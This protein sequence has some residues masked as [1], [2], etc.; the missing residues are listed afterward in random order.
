MGLEVFLVFVFAL[1]IFRRV[2]SEFKEQERKNNLYQDGTGDNRVMEDIPR[3]AGDIRLHTILTTTNHSERVGI[4]RRHG[5]NSRDS[6]RNDKHSL[7]GSHEA[8]RQH[9]KKAARV[10]RDEM[11]NSGQP[12][13]HLGNQPLAN[14]WGKGGLSTPQA[15]SIITVFSSLTT[16]K[17]PHPK[18][19]NGFGPLSLRDMG[20]TERHKPKERKGN[21]LIHF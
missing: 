17:R 19:R 6:P 10:L 16:K 20:R 11:R 15:G 1:L 7:G 2:S 5:N 21:N 9:K 4:P 12:K 18:E 3:L 13:Q 14:S 8:P